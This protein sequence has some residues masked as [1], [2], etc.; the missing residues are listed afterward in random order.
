MAPNGQQIMAKQRRANER[1]EKEGPRS[2]KAE[3]SSKANTER[4]ECRFRWRRRSQRAPAERSARKQ[5]TNTPG[6]AIEALRC[7]VAGADLV[8]G[9]SQ[10]LELCCSSARCPPPGTD[11]LPA[12]PRKQPSSQ[13]SSQPG[14]Q[15]TEVEDEDEDG[16][17]AGPHHDGRT[18]RCPQRPRRP[19]RQRTHAGTHAHTQR[20][21]PV[22][23]SGRTDSL[24]RTSLSSSL[25]RGGASGSSAIE[26]DSMAEGRRA[27]CH[28]RALACL[29]CSAL[30]RPDSFTVGERGVLASWWRTGGAA[31]Q[32][33]L[34]SWVPRP[35]ADFVSGSSCR[36]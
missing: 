3:A 6:T 20:L 5:Q 34:G 17:A 32:A 30:L 14:A 16:D 4:S 9:P 26:R 18:D 10:V 21:S 22:S 13:P 35:L 11:R 28:A 36:R 31:E 15:E 27:A 7:Y 12:Q 24:R 33:G 1:E 25:H 19:R 2:G 23:P 29:R 8:Q